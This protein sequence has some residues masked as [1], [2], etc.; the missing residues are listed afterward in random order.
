MLRAI[1]AFAPVRLKNAKKGRPFCW[2]TVKLAH[3]IKSFTCNCYPLLSA[4]PVLTI[5]CGWRQALRI[6]VYWDLAPLKFSTQA[7]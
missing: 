7:R 6:S 4:F 2:P 5:P 3:C 1:L